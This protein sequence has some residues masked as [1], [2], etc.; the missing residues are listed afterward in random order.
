MLLKLLVLHKLLDEQ[1]DD[2]KGAPEKDVCSHVLAEVG[3][4]CAG[5]LTESLYH[6]GN[7]KLDKNDCTSQDH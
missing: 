7:L 2:H 3:P 6:V 5:I 1:Y 4:S